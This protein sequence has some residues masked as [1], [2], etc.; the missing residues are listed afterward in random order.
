MI[1]EEIIR[2][3]AD[4]KGTEPSDLDLVLQNWIETD[5]LQELIHHDSANWALRFEVPNHSVTVTS[6]NEI[7][8]DGRE[9]RTFC[10]LWPRRS[11]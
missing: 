3:I 7:L 4:A 10:D 1:H 2:A 6:E 11:R 9:E 8:V 5:A